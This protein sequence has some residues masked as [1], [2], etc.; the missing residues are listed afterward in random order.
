MAYG[1]AAF[2]VL[3]AQAP[4]STVAPGNALG[5]VVGPVSLGSDA[6]QPS[7]EFDLTNGTDKAVTAWQVTI[8]AALTDGTVRQTAMAKDAYLAYE[9][10]IPDRGDFIRPHADVHVSVRLADLFGAL[11]L[12]SVQRL[13]ASGRSV[14]FADRTWSGDADKVRR[15]FADRD[16][17]QV[18][19]TD[20]INALRK[21]RL[22]AQGL[23]A[24]RAALSEMNKPDQQDRDNAVKVT[25]RKNLETAINATSRASVTPDEQMRTWLAS[26]ERRW[27]VTQEHSIQGPQADIK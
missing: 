12:G 22:S 18:A 4:G 11:P 19:L 27:Q 10:L 8:E 15:T 3:L 26:L 6:G 24:L 5:I 23:A 21:A 7:V 17:A 1:I 14:I 25:M 13:A 20:V 16:R 2:V 9:G